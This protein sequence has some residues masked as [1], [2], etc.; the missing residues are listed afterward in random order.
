MDSRLC[1]FIEFTFVVGLCQEIKY[2]IGFRIIFKI[3][4]EF[5]WLPIGFIK[6]LFDKPS[7]WGIDEN[8]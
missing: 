6:N 4:M 7:C 2:V 8:S 5:I 3:T 1:E